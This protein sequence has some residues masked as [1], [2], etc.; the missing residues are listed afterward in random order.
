MKTDPEKPRYVSVPW[1]ADRWQVTQQT[2]LKMIATQ[3]LPAFKVGR[4]WRIN[5]A[6]VEALET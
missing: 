5:R 6:D 1:T 2:V 4:H 3:K